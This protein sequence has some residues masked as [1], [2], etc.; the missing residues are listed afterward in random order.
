MDEF[1]R[2]FAPL[3][4]LTEQFPDEK[5][6]PV[7]LDSQDWDMTISPAMTAGVT[8]LLQTTMGEKPD[9]AWML[10]PVLRIVTEAIYILGYERGKR[11]Q[12]NE[13]DDLSAF[14]F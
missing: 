8:V 6:D 13:S 4:K 7:I 9:T 5:R 11:E 10:V 12:Q 2:Y 1:E 14:E 3:L